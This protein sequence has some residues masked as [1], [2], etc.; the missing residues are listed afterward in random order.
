[1]HLQT[2]PDG[3]DAAAII[4]TLFVSVVSCHWDIADWLVCAITGPFAFD[5]GQTFAGIQIPNV[6]ACTSLVTRLH[7]MFPFIDCIGWDLAIDHDGQPHVLEWNSGH[8]GI[9]LLESIAGP[10][11]R[12]LD[13]ADR[14]R[15]RG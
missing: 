9:K 11:F 8:N 7:D 3:S 4:M 14:W 5:T 2:L 6:T 15:W 10:V 1:M 12:D 13:W